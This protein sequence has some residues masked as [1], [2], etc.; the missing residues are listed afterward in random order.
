MK[1]YKMIN[2]LITKKFD[3][4]VFYISTI[5]S[6]QLFQTSTIFSWH[7]K[8][9]DHVSKSE[10]TTPTS[11]LKPFKCCDL[12]VFRLILIFIYPWFLIQIPGGVQVSKLNFLDHCHGEICISRHP[13]AI[14]M[15]NFRQFFI[16]LQQ[17]STL[18]YGIQL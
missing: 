17:E 16:L 12:V 2:P 1:N 15:Q 11:E 10:L 9:Y 3:W 13:E 18:F 7:V 14:K 6:S 8:I 4:F 5:C